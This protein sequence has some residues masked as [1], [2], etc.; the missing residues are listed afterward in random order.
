MVVLEVLVRIEQNSLKI[1]LLVV[2]EHILVGSASTTDGEMGYMA[3]PIVLLQPPAI[4]VSPKQFD[5]E[6]CVTTQISWNG[7]IT[8]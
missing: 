1:I 2:N 6:C 7:H 5:L 8:Q 3:S 4:T